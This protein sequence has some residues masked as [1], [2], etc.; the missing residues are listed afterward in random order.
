MGVPSESNY[1][2]YIARKYLLQYHLSYKHM[3]KNKQSPVTLHTWLSL[4]MT[5]WKHL[6]Q[7]AQG[8][9]GSMG[10][11]WRLPIWN[12]TSIARQEVERNCAFSYS[13]SAWHSFGPASLNGF[14]ICWYLGDKATQDRFYLI[15]LTI[16]TAWLWWKCKE[17]P[18]AVKQPLC[19]AKGADC[20]SKVNFQSCV[21]YRVFCVFIHFFVQ[22]VPI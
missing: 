11:Q 1:I 18:L 22:V 10:L 2:T 19:L 9:P 5:V 17:I 21:S 13:E 12:T 20:E 16:C 3:Q 7:E 15:S 4:P 14:F 8:G 6:Q